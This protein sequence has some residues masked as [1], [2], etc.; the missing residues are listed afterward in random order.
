MLLFLRDPA[1]S[2]R[3][4]ERHRCSQ[5]VDSL[6]AM[7]AL[8]LDSSSEKLNQGLHLMR[9]QPTLHITESVWLS[10]RNGYPSLR[11]WARPVAATL[12]AKHTTGVV[13]VST[14]VADPWSRRSTVFHVAVNTA[15]K[16]Q[17]SALLALPLF[18][19]LLFIRHYM[20]CGVIL[21]ATS[22]LLPHD[23]KHAFLGTMQRMQERD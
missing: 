15:C 20:T 5:L 1:I 6:I 23:S 12:I 19:F 22:W 16:V 3:C 2:L 13:L 14:V 17:I 8:A 21:L 11:H 9:L 7:V 18:P 10:S 4:E